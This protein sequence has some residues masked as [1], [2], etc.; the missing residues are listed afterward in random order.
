MAADD[1]LAYFLSQKEFRHAAKIG[2]LAAIAKNPVTLLI[3]FK[4]I[5]FGRRQ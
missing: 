4:S 2:E 1:P 3:K 5:F